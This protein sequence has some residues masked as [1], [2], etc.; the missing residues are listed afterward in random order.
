MREPVE[1]EVF[2]ARGQLAE[3]ADDLSPAHRFL[4]R[5]EQK[6]GDHTEGD[7]CDDAKGAEP[8]ERGVEKVRLPLRRAGGHGPVGEHQFQACYLG[9][10]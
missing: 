2:V 4:A 9:G 5:L 6:G 1:L 3:P 8:H 10:D 7:R